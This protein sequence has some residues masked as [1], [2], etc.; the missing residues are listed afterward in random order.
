LH[1]GRINHSKKRKGQKGEKVHVYT[2]KPRGG[3]ASSHSAKGG[4]QEAGIPLRLSEVMKDKYGRKRRLRGRS[5]DM[6]YIEGTRRGL[7]Q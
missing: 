7:K 3:R 1:A 2:T 4:G 6:S 5:E